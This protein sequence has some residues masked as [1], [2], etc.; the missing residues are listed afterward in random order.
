M[1]PLVGQNE[2]VTKDEVDRPPRLAVSLLR[3][4]QILST[5]GFPVVYKLAADLKLKRE[6]GKIIKKSIGCP[7]DLEGRGTEKVLMVV[8]AT[9]A[10][11]TMLINGMVNYILGIK[12]EDKFRFKLVVEDSKVS[13]TQSQTK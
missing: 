1:D 6:K 3:E 9:G 7:R 10:G 12:W 5:A 2:K 8:G 13:Q 11:K 4:S